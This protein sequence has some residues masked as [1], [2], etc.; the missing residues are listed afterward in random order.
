MIN[1]LLK[2]NVSLGESKLSIENRLTEECR[3]IYKK[4]HGIFK[5]VKVELMTTSEIVEVPE[6]VIVKLDKKY[7]TFADFNWVKRIG[8]NRHIYK[9][10][11]FF[12]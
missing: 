9:F 12:Q 3:G 10:N 7:N 8:T 1:V 4:C 11:S 5:G 2:L 6:I